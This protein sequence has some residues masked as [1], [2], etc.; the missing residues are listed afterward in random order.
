MPDGVMRWFDAKT[1]EAEIARGSRFFPARAKDIEH[2]AR[3][4]GA[5]VH[6]D[7]ERLD[8]VERAID[9]RLR[10]GARVSHRHH[11]FGTLAGAREEAM[12][13]LAQDASMHP[14]LREPATHPL[15][16]ARA[17]ATSVAAGDVPGALTLFAP[18]VV[19]HV[20]EERLTGRAGLEAW[21][22]AS[23][24]L[25]SAR[26]AS[27]RGAGNEAVLTW[28]ARGP[29][30]P[31]LELRCRLAHGQV[32]E[33]WVTEPAAV[34]HA[35]EA[36]AEAGGGPQLAI[37]VKGEVGEEDK[38]QAEDA[39]RK[40]IARLHEPVLF[41][42][43]KLFH[44]PDPARTR[45]AEVQVLLDVD[46]DLVRAH[47]AAPT[48]PEATNALTDRLRDQLE[49]RAQ[50]REYLHSS[51]G[52]AHP[53]EWRHG[54]VPTIRPP[55]FDRPVEERELVRHK[56]FAV[57]ELTPDEA[58]FDME[59]LDYDF[60]LFRDLASGSDALMERV[61][62]GAF[63]MTRSAHSDMEVGPTAVQL[64]IS[65]VEVPALRLEDAIELLN[66][67]GDTHLF[68]V[69]PTTGRGDVLYRRYDGHYGLIAPE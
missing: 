60:Y 44:E 25:G 6:F 62:P 7:I 37:F 29:D 39:V 41:A 42:R 10:R 15:A 22:E 11:G 49:H 18:D 50:R 59:V 2:V 53:G 66:V 19:L 4:A 28:D 17:W 12:K 3:H 40:V 54:D 20:G 36:V 1:G 67:E 48:M 34:E 65:D 43:V 8:G 55:Y 16:V 45:P 57:G 64:E 24:L 27:I 5:R 32:A 33:L 61:G 35:G 68:F 38:A 52:V 56:T 31:G 58:A 30:Q 47:V 26:H 9:V 14:E 13:G 63:R 51:D 21:L 23:P 46:G 69:E